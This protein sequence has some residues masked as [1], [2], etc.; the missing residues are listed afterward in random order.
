MRIS[1]EVRWPEIPSIAGKSAMQ[2]AGA[3][4]D[5]L[6]RF[7][8]SLAARDQRIALAINAADIEVV[9]AVPTDAPDFDVVCLRVYDDGSSVRRLYVWVNG[10]WRYVS[11][12]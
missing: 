10:T 6:R 2:L 11:L 8:I 7:R 1:K 5:V 3:A 4:L 9:S 12:T